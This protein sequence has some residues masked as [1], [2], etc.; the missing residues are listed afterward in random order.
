MTEPLIQL[1]KVCAG[2]GS[3]PVLSDADLTVYDNDYLGI[4]GPNGGGKST[5]IKTVLGLIKPYSGKIVL[6]KKIRFGYMPQ[7]TL[8]DIRFPITVSDVV[9]SGLMHRKKLLRGFSSE[10]RKKVMM[11]LEK[12]SLSDF[13]KTPYGELS[14]GQI[15]RVMLARAIISDPDVLILDEPSAFTDES[16]S[17]NIWDILKDFNRTGTVITVSH[18]TGVISSNVKNVACV[19][20]TVHYHA[21]NEITEGLLQKYSCPVEIIAHGTV[22]HRVVKKHGV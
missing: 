6:K 9:L 16:F 11:L 12:F 4:I 2:Y 21:G 19:N 18:D 22:P 1:H 5:L 14:G 15:Q 13:Q 10:H 7:L 3:E 17:K 8:S 20:R